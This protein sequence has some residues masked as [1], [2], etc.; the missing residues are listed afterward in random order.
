MQKSASV[1]IV[2]LVFFGCSLTMLACPRLSQAQAAQGDEVQHEVFDDDLLN[3]DLGTP[4]GEWTFAGHLPSARTRL[5]RPRMT[6][7]PELYQ[8]VEHL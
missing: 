6:F 8:S 4:Y 2:R 1:F 3:A 5:L 7:V